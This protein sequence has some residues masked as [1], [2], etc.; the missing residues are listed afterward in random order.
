MSIHKTVDNKALDQILP[1]SDNTL[2][3]NKAA[4][5]G[6]SRA[7]QP[8][9][10]GNLFVEKRNQ[11]HILFL[12]SPRDDLSHQPHQPA[13]LNQRSDG[14]PNCLHKSKFFQKLSFDKFCFSVVKIKFGSFSP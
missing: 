4:N 8:N 10:S 6:H 14:S 3:R 5:S 13:V 2:F 12:N 7:A 11:Y 1:Y 9:C